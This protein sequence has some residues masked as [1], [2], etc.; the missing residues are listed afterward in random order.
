[1]RFIAG[2]LALLALGSTASAAGAA[3]PPDR[4]AYAGGC[5]ALPGLPGGQHV[6]FQA[7]TLGEYL[8][9]LPD[10]TFIVA[11][12]GEDAGVA[13]EPSLAAEWV[14]SEATG[15][16][17][18]LTP[19]LAGGRA[20]TITP[21]PADGCAVYPEA[22]L[23]ATNVPGPALSYGTVNG[24]VE[25]HMHWMTYE[26]F[27]GR[28]HCGRPW[29][30]YGIAYALP[31]CA[32]VEGPQGVDA[33]F[34]NFFNYG[35]PA[36][37][38][39]TSGFPKLASFSRDNLTYEGT[40]WRWIQRAWAG[41]LRMMVMGVN[42]NRVLCELQAVKE[43][44]CNE[45][46]T[47]RRAVRDMR[48]LQKYVDAQAGG[49]GK[50]FMEIV[51]DP[52]Q[53][54]RAINAGKMAVLLE[55]E[56][57]EPFD[58]RSADQPTCS[59][60]KVDKDLD[61]MHDIGIRSML[62]LNKYDNPLTGVRFDSGPTGVLINAANRASAGSF[63]DA[64]TCTG[65][66][67]D[68]TIETGSPALSALV[69]GVFGGAGVGGGTAPVY[70]PAPHCNTKGLTALGK[71]VV[72]RMMDKG[73]IVNPDHMSQAAVDD[74]LTLLEARKYSGVIS[75]HGWMDP[76]NWPRLWKLGGIAFP[77]HSAA[78]DYVKDWQDYRPA[79]TPYKFGWGYG[80][81]LGGLSHQPKPVSGAAAGGTLTYPFKS[82]DG[83]GVVLSRQ[84]T[85]DRTFDYAREGVAHYGLY[86]DWFADLARLGGPQMAADMNSGAEA[87]LEMWERATGTPSS[88]A[89]RSPRVALTSAGLPA[90]RIGADW[91]ALLQR[92]G[93][94]QQRTVAWSYC[95]AGQG[96]TRAADVAVLSAAGKVVLV[97]SRAV[98][99]SV[100]RVFVG[101]SVRALR[102][103][104][105]VRSVG[106][107]VYTRRRSASR[108]EVFSVRGGRVRVVG[109]A[110]ASLARSG[111]VL[112][113]A[114]AQVRR[115]KASSVLPTYQPSKIESKT[116]GALRGFSLA[117][118][119]DPT[120]NRGLALLC[121]LQMGAY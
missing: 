118:S 2:L 69:T 114:V 44:N 83:R 111:R 89:C 117:G 1:M 96:N 49:P 6:R 41:G 20:V 47:V 108:V 59:Q 27:G 63:F 31:D 60:A 79:S 34:Q 30:K 87:Y 88:R 105:G 94:P 112:R 13:P 16:A 11:R 32:S 10:R 90:L 22:P 45:M 9:Y 33:P 62:L 48:E 95:V 58:C 121:Q 77:G 61:E 7:T 86:A 92:A 98:G 119:A 101:S 116:G 68:N 91:T 72:T 120:T 80:A 64:K 110:T 28:F 35:N 100:R 12:A 18:T 37:P 51:T 103:L 67:H 113:A 78:P 5:Y 99:R 106:A 102:S 50:G 57:S 55:I 24:I 4:Y 38:H 71:H 85:G 36:Q 23:D 70:P 14:A 56:I 42:E 17:L 43:T 75:P 53:A 107:G 54:R 66:L 74:T 46:D 25:G 29:H 97:G 8:L 39:D 15:G 109:V 40:Y 21:V 26:Y 81:D 76:G 104:R 52:Q 93:Q 73:M 3:G 82:A 65:R 115:A 84:K 19:K